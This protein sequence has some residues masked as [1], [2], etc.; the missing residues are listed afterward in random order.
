VVV[1]VLF[2]FFPLSPSLFFFY[3]FFFSWW[4]FICLVRLLNKSKLFNYSLVISFIKNE[5]N[6]PVIT[7]GYKTTV[8]AYGSTF[9]A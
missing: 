1:V 7:N 3:R 4:W 2:I 9:I 8:P 5:E 6:K